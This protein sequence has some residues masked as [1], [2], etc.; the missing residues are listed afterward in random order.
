MKIHKR[1]IDIESP[2]EVV[3]QI[4]RCSPPP[5]PPPRLKLPRGSLALT[6]SCLSVLCADLHVDRVGRRGRGYVVV[7]PTPRAARAKSAR[8]FLLTLPAPPVFALYSHHPE[9]SVF[10]CHSFGMQSLAR[11]GLVTSPLS[12]F[13]SFFGRV[14]AGKAKNLSRDTFSYTRSGHLGLCVVASFRLGGVRRYSCSRE[15]REIR[16][17]SNQSAVEATT[18][19]ARSLCSLALS[20]LSP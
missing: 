17:I 3:K 4:V 16:R 7:E 1:L 18:R 14:M 5:P 15:A 10:C 9:L 13:F 8:L 11:S 6:G 20:P 12:Y 2:A 19:A